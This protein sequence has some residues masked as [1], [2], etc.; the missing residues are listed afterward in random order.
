[1]IEL[2]PYNHELAEEWNALV[3]DSRNGTFLID[4]HYMDYHSALFN[5]VSMMFVDGKGRVVAVLPANIDYATAEVTSHGGL[6]YGGLIVSRKTS[7]VQVMEALRLACKYLRNL[8]G[9]TLVYKPIPYIYTEYPSQE[10]LYF[11]F[12]YGAQLCAR[13]ISQ[14]IY[15]PRALGMNELRRRCIKR[16]LAVG[17]EVVAT[18][19]PTEFWHILDCN[20]RER[21]GVHPVHSVSELRLLMNRFP[22][23]IRHYAVRNREGKVIAGTVVYDTGRVAH[24]QYIATNHEG[25]QTG[26]FDLLIS[27]LLQNEYAGHQYI[28]FGV[29]TEH[30]GEVMNEGLV[31]QKESFGGRG[32]CYDAWRLNLLQDFQS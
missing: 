21:H 19:D 23:N 25:R 13:G 22:D 32:V 26:A 15:M 18:D 2:V 14:A 27:R 28:D 17:N 9:T 7:T 31:F 12:R 4:R 6:T 30:G 1:M 3:A 5:D 20:L 8:G 29:S 10:D 16:S 11:L 24:T